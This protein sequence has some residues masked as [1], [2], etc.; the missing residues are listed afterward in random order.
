MEISDTEG[1]NAD[2][3][4][5]VAAG[6]VP[7]TDLDSGDN[8]FKVDATISGSQSAIGGTYSDT[9]GITMSF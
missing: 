9:V 7:Q 8:T 5:A 1:A 6:Y 3:I 4:F 2:V